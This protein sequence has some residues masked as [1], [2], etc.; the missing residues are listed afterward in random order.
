MASSPLADRPAETAIPSSAWPWRSGDDADYLTCE[1]LAPW[2]HGFFTR[3][4]SPRSP[5]DLT[6]RLNP[7]ATVLRVKQVHGDRTLTAT[8]IAQTPSADGSPYPPADGVLAE[9]ENQAAWVCT[10]DCT[11]V[12][13]GD[14]KTGM[15]AAVHA[16]WRGTAQK[17][18]PKAIARLLERG[19]TLETL[20]IALGPA[21]SGAVYQVHQPVADQLTDTLQ[22][23]PNQ[24]GQYNLHPVQPDS[25]AGKARL[26]VRH[27]NLLQL[28]ELGLKPEQLA[29]APHCTY[30]DRDRFFSYRRDATKTVQWS[31]IVSGIVSGSQS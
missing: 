2:S 24:W 6:P 21:I 11:P 17:I 30:S 29:I 20:R 14:L 16:G 28:L 4:F 26:N 1:L 25:E 7:D 22:T 27:M 31:G 23:T 8:E 12:L 9:T 15:V 19:A 3:K 10:A 18:V 13:I 5:A